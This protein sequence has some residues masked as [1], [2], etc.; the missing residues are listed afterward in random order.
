MI[1]ID[2]TR[3]T[4]TFYEIEK[5][6]EKIKEKTKTKTNKSKECMHAAS[7]LFPR[8]MELL[9]FASSLFTFKLLGIPSVAFHSC[10]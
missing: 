2:T 10:S 4:Y 7:E 6:K 3:R 9:V 5:R 1:T 8:S